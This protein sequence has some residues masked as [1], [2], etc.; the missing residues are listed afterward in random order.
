[1]ESARTRAEKVALGLGGLGLLLSFGAYVNIQFNAF[2]F[3]AAGLSPREIGS[4]AALGNLA[5]L[6]SPMIAG[7]WTDR[8]GHPRMILSLYLLAGAAALVALPALR[9]FSE[10]A[11]GYFL[12]QLALSPISPLST[13]LILSRTSAGNGGFLALRAMGTLGF[14]LV[15]IW[16]SSSLGRIGLPAAYRT[17]AFLLLCSLPVFLGLRRTPSEVRRPGQELRAALAYLWDPRLRTIYIGCGLGFFCNALGVTVLGNYITGPLGGSPQDIARAWGVATGF[18]MV[19]FFLSIPFVR[20]F[21][22]KTFVLAGLAGTSIRWALAAW[23]P[24]FPFFL[25]AQAL[26]GLMVTGVFTG[27]SLLLARILPAD[28]LA[29]GT[30]AAALVNGGIMSVAGSGLSG[31]IWQAAGLRAACWVTSLV[32]ALAALFFWK[33]GPDPASA[34]PSPAVGD[35]IRLPFPEV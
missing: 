18:E 17:M 30:A 23:A 12:I 25:A 21:G 24:S 26:H 3:Q 13:S 14:F 29:S 27:E 6:F 35:G 7:W 11:P 1:M 28:R 10:L 22:L 20:R 19:F 4:V 32:A 15:S 33:F 16:L 5:S 8:C 34:S 9:G 2:L 31:W